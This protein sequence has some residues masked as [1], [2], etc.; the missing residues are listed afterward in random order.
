MGGQTAG[1][2]AVISAEIPP[3][4]GPSPHIHRKDDEL[5]LVVEGSMSYFSNEAWTLVR[6]GGAVYLPRN[7]LHTYRNDGDA[8]SRHWIITTPSGFENFLPRRPR[9][10]ARPGELDMGRIIEIS[11]NHGIELVLGNPA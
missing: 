4:V 9:R 11:A 8:P 5:F 10:P 2:L 1:S 7:S 6:P 3:G